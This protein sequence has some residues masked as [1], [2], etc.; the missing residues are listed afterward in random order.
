MSRVG[1]SQAHV[2]H[3][4]SSMQENF[5]KEEKGTQ[6]RTFWSGYF[7]GGVRGLPRERV[8]PKK[9]DTSLEPREIKL[10]GRDIPGFCRDIPEAP[11]KFEKKKVCVQ[12]LDPTLG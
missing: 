12:F 11:E 3:W 2:G 4:K 8:G 7:P 1:T 9:F 6:T 5:V 10:L